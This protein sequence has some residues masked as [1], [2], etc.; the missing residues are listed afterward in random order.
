[1]TGRSRV[2][3]PAVKRCRGGDTACWYSPTTPE[4]HN[5]PV[6]SSGTSEAAHAHAH[7]RVRMVAQPASVPAVRRFVDDA[8]TTW[9]RLDLIDD[10]SLSVTEL[11][12][13]ATLHSRSTYFDVELHTAADAVRVSVSDGGAA[14]GRTIASR[15]DRAHAGNPADRDPDVESMTGRGLFIVSALAASWGID[16]LAD[17]TRVWA[18]FTVAGPAGP[19]PP[20]LSGLLDE[21]AV[22]PPSVGEEVTVIRLLGCPPGPLLAHDDNLADV[23]RELNLFGASHHD[24]EAVAA[25]RRIGEVVQA[26]AMSWG[27]ARLV[28]SQALQEG[29]DR[30]DIA[31][32][33]SEPD[34]IPVRVQ[35]L[36]D[37]VDA[38]EAMSAQGL[39]MTLPAPPDVQRWR[40]WVEGEMVDQVR[41]GRAPVAFADWVAPGRA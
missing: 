18:D 11:A 10:V 31:V 2:S 20:V 6:S 17:G 26:S 39:L 3:G 30:V 40:D 29:R 32:V 5:H 1:M 16:D 38:A 21:A 8:L 12:T 4:G 24:A 27:A 36:R 28:A 35:I 19:Q 14:A 33:V 7:A 15:V 22:D 37:A 13:N 23:A 9:G 41:T 25:A 34:Q